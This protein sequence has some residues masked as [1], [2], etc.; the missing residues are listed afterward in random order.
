MKFS[1]PYTE[2]YIIDWQLMRYRGRKVDGVTLVGH[3]S[4]TKMMHM[5]ANPI[6]FLRYRKDY[7]YVRNPKDIKL[8]WV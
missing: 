8:G 6:R 5:K 3:N 4:R 2:T 1:V 7:G